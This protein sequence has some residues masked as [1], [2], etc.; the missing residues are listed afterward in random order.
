MEKFPRSQK[1]AL[2]DRIQSTAL[3]VL[4]ALTEADEAALLE[5]R[6]VGA[7]LAQ[8]IRQFFSEAHN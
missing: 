5:V 6:D 7:V 4:E 2:G 8:S 3:G 1:F